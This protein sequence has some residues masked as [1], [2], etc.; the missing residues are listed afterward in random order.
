MT[1]ARFLMN[2]WMIRV[3]PVTDSNPMIT[4]IGS[5]L[6]KMTEKRVD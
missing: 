2:P 5:T 6:P 1:A 3:N 4:K